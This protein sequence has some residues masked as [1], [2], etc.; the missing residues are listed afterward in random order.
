MLSRVSGDDH[1]VASACAIFV[2]KS[3]EDLLRVA[4]PFLLNG[5]RVTRDAFIPEVCQ[6]T[7]LIDHSEPDLHIA[8]KAGGDITADRIYLL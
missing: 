5:V 6:S 8:G 7:K 3:R 4:W 2:R 1:Q